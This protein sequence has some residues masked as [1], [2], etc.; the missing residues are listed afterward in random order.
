[1]VFSTIF[2]VGFFYFSPNSFASLTELPTLKLTSDLSDKQKDLRCEDTERTEPIWT[3]CTTAIGGKCA[4]CP[5]KADSSSWKDPKIDVYYNYPENKRKMTLSDKECGWSAGIRFCARKAFPGNAEEKTADENYGNTT[6]ATPNP[7]VQLCAYEDPMDG[8]DKNGAENKYHWQTKNQ[9]RANLAGSIA[10][11]MA[12]GYF[13]GPLGPAVGALIGGLVVAIT[14]TYNH[15]VE[16]NLGCVDLPIAKGPPPF[17]NDCW[18]TKYAISPL[19]DLDINSTFMSPKVKLTFCFDAKAGNSS[20][21]EPAVCDL[22]NDSQQSYLLNPNSENGY[23]S[24]GAID[25]NYVISGQPISDKR[26]FKAVVS[27]TRSSKVCVYMSKDIKGKAVNVFQGCLPRTGYMYTPIIS[28]SANSTTESPKLKVTF[29]GSNNTIEVWQNSDDYLD[30]ACRDLEQVNLCAQRQCLT[31][32]DGVTV[33]LNMCDSWDK[34]VCLTGYNVPPVVV[35]DSRNEP[36]KSLPNTLI[37]KNSSFDNNSAYSEVNEKSELVPTKAQFTRDIWVYKRPATSI[38]YRME[39]EGYCSN[40]TG[41]CKRTDAQDTSKCLEYKQLLT[42][43]QDPYYVDMAKYTVRA[44]TPE[45]MGLCIDNSDAEG[46]WVKTKAGNYIY[47]VP[48]NCKEIRVELWGAGAG[49]TNGTGSGNDHGGGAGGY[50]SALVP[51]VSGAD[52]NVVVGAGGAG[53]KNGGQTSLRRSA[54]LVTNGVVTLA[55]GPVIAYGGTIS[56]S[57]GTGG[58]SSCSA[59]TTCELQKNGGNGLSASCNYMQGGAA[60]NPDQSQYVYTSISACNSNTDKMTKVP[61]T[62]GCAA[63]SC[64]GSAIKAYNG[65][66]ADGKARISCTKFGN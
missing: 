30:N 63:D 36:I 59:D 56:S 50:V 51:V 14:S 46:T 45:E 3:K 10:G 54:A 53:N 17:C 29:P 55:A 62:G 39:P 18:H 23:V 25:L 48:E 37:P 44:A 9:D 58:G 20:V 11:G 57:R 12:I 6:G 22:N 64:V 33:P 1:M 7:R 32:K 21:K 66:G 43:D 52:Y 13:F 49:G 60:W 47:P 40:T 34:K 4:V 2:M 26:E 35:V 16:N 65:I 19:I 5:P 15:N 28:P 8:M 27:S 61:G 38:C 42:K 41:A 24:K 31:V